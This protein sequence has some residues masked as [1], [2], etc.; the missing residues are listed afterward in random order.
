MCFRI[1]KGN[2]GTC[3]MQEASHDRWLCPGTSSLASLNLD[4]P[5]T[6]GVIVCSAYLQGCRWSD[7]TSW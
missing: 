5:P 7:G 4:S 3:T 2:V 6:N 1:R